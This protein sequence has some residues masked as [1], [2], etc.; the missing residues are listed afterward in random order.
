[1]KEMNDII[2]LQ[3]GLLR[4]RFVD[5]EVTGSF[6]NKIGADYDA[7]GNKSPLRVPRNPREHNYLQIKD[8]EPDLL[9]P[10][11]IL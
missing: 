1:M 10:S 9:G 8:N 7:R 3:N 6:T 11:L 4:P 2:I 5:L